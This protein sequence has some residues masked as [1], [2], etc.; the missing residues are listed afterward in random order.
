V[1]RSQ[2]KKGYKLNY[3]PQEGTTAAKLLSNIDTEDGRFIKPIE[4]SDFTI[5]YQQPAIKIKKR[6]NQLKQTIKSISIAI[7][8]LQVE[9]SK[10]ENNL[11][12]EE[13][14]KIDGA[15]DSEIINAHSEA[16]LPE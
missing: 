12:D 8:V 2:P 1:K 9:L 5:D 4:A 15:G 11:P 3:I 14:L 6:E 13:K 10:C 7:R 16:A